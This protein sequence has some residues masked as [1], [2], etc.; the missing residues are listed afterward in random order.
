MQHTQKLYSEV[1]VNTDSAFF[2]KKLY[3]EQFF[4]EPRCTIEVLDPLF[5][6]NDDDTEIQLDEAQTKLKNR[7]L[8]ISGL[9]SEKISEI[10]RTLDRL[11][12]EIFDLT[13][14]INYCKACCYYASPVDSE[15]SI[16]NE[17]VSL[18]G[19][20]GRITI[21]ICLNI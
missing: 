7:R 14:R 6:G 20:Y 15:P 1:V 2:N 18:S 17:D 16:D 19:K 4:L 13:T 11:Y 9:L 3:D 5:Y 8:V 10:R 12:S 21:L